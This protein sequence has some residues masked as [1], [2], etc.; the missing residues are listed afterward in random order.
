MKKRCFGLYSP[1]AAECGLCDD[2]DQCNKISE[3][4][5][6]EGEDNAVRLAVLQALEVGDLSYQ[7]LKEVVLRLLGDDG[8]WQQGTSLYYHLG[9]LKRNGM[10]VMYRSGR[11]MVYR[12]VASAARD[13]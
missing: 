13:N 11:S 10:V 4:E 7:G 3:E 12:S 2:V 8:M 6:E 5:E 1:S 9:R